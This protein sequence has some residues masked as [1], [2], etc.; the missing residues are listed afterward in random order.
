MN[1]EQ[2]HRMRKQAAPEWL[3]KAKEWAS[4]DDYE[5]LKNVGVGAGSALAA[6][7]G[8]YALGGLVPGLKDNRR[9]RLLTSLAAGGAAGGAGYH[10]GKDIRN[11]DYDKLNPWRKSIEDDPSLTPAQMA[12]YK[13]RLLAP[14]IPPAGAGTAAG[15]ALMQQARTAQDQAEARRQAERK[16][17]ADT[18]DKNLVRFL[19]GKT[20]SATPTS[21]AF[22]VPP[23]TPLDSLEARDRIRKL[24]NG[25]MVVDEAGNIYSPAPTRED[26]LEAQKARTE[27]KLR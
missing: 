7:A 2:L 23:D 17:A 25:T 26:V 13:E 18:A 5:N 27:R 3:N 14:F 9:M 15:R 20:V 12:K 11:F 19:Q 16:K 22:T 8:T 6:G 10:Y 4:K 24:L 1:Y 21:K